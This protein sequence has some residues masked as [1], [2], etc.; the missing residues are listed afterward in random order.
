MH[1]DIPKY[2][3]KI[4]YEIKDLNRVISTKSYDLLIK[5]KNN[6]EIN[7]NNL[8]NPN[9]KHSTYIFKSKITNDNSKLI[10]N[11]KNTFANKRNR[12]D[13]EKMYRTVALC[14]DNPRVS[15]GSQNSN[16]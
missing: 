16:Q 11:I 12:Q 14:S 5:D 6:S 13:R 7:K 3:K 15:V 9:N 1:I 4:N 2:E 8:I 10:G